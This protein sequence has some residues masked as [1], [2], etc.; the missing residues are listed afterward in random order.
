MIEVFFSKLKDI[1]CFL[2]LLNEIIFGFD[3]GLWCQNCIFLT[4]SF[5][6]S[7]HLFPVKVSY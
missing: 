6:V 5:V 4:H 1:K 3:Q 7:F 2:F